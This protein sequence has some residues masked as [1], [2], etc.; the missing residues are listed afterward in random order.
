MLCSTVL[1][2]RNNNYVSGL[3]LFIVLEK[4]LVLTIA[5]ERRGV[6]RVTAIPAGTLLVSQARNAKNA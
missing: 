2:V 3:G 5:A 6:S 4:G 1:L